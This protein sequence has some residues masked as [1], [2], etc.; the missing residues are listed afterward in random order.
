[1]INGQKKNGLIFRIRRVSQSLLLIFILFW[2]VGLQG[3]GGKTEGRKGP[4]VTPTITGP[5][6]CCVNTGGYIYYTQNGMT[7]YVWSVSPGGNFTGQGTNTIEVSWLASG[8]QSVSVI[9]NG[10]SG[11]TSQNIQVQENITA[12]VAISAS[13]NNVCSGTLVTFTATPLN[14]GI[15]PVYQWKVNGINVGFNTQTYDYAP[16]NGDEVTCQMTSGELCVTN[17]PVTS[18]AIVM[19][20]NPILPVSVSISTLTN[21]SC[22]GAPVTFTAAPVNG[23]TLPVYQWYVNSNLQA[24]TTGNFT[25]TPA[26]N[27]EVY[28]SMTSNESCISGNP[29][30]SNPII[31]T[32]SDVQ[33]VGVTIATPNNPCCVGQTALF[34]ATPTNGGTSPAYQWMVNGSPQGSNSPIFSFIP[35]EGDLVTCRLTSNS[36]CATGNPAYSTP[37]P[38]SVQSYVPVSVAISASSNPVCNGTG[39]T[40]SASAANGGIA[41]EY[42][43]YVN[44]TNVGTNSAQYTY[45]PSNNDQVKCILISNTLCPA[46]SPATSNLINMVVISSQLPTVT[47]AASSNPSCQ[48]ASVTFTATAQNAGSNPVYQWKIDGSNVGPNS[49]TYSFTPLNGQVVSCAVTSNATCNSGATATSNMITMTV[50]SSLNVSVSIAVSANPICAGSSATFTATG[51]HGG[52]SPTYQWKVGGVNAGSNSPTYTYTPNNGDVVTCVMTSS[53]SCS[54]GNPATSNAITMSVSLSLPAS[55]SISANQ[56][57]ACAGQVVS[58]SATPVNGGSSPTYTWQVNSISVGSGPTFTTSPNNGDQVTCIMTSSSS[59]ATGSP[60]TSNSV[61]MTINPYTAVGVSILSSQNPSCQG[62]SVVFTATPVNPGTTPVYEWKVNGNVTGGNQSTL[63]YVPVSGDKIT[64]QL[65][66]SVLCPLSNPVLSNQITQTVDP[67]VNASV[68]VSPSANPVCSGTQVTFSAMP[69]NGGT[70]PTYQWKV[71][72]L[73]AGSNNPTLILTPINS[74]VVECRMTSSLMCVSGNPVSSTPVTMVVSTQLTPLITITSSSNPFC[75]GSLV[76]FNASSTYGGSAPEYQWRVNGSPVGSNSPNYSYIPQNGDFV[77][78]QLTSSLACATGPVTSNY[79][80][81]T[82]NTTT[83]AGITI[84]ANANPV[85]QGSPVTFTA[86][87]VNGGSSPGYQWKVNGSN[88]GTNSPTF[89]FTPVNNDIVTCVL[90]SNASCVSGS[91]FT[92]LPV[93]LSVTSA[94]AATI[95][96]TP[97]FNPF[98]EGSAVTFNSSITNGGSAPVYNWQVNG[99]GMGTNSPTFTHSPNNGDV[100]T[101]QLTSNASCISGPNPVTSP[102]VVMSSAAT[103]TAGVS[104]TASANP[105]C[106]GT[107]V[108][109]TATPT[110]GGSTPNYQWKV[111]GV[112]AGTNNPVFSYIPSNGQVITCVM[113]SSLSCSINNPAT[114]NA[115][116]MTVTPPQPVSVTVTPSINPICIGSTVTLTATPVNGGSSPVYLWRIN[117][118]QAGTNSNTYAYIPTN[119]DVITCQ[120]T[121]NATCVSNNPAI[122]PSLVMQVG[123]ELP[124]AITISASANPFCTGSNVTFTSVIA[125]GGTAPIYEWF[126]NGL[127]VG[128]NSPTYVYPPVSGDIV[129]CRVTSNQSCICNNPANSNNITMIAGSGLP[130]SVSISTPTTTVCAG[131]LVIFTATPTNGGVNPNYQW[132]I[133]NVNAGINNATF[134]PVVLNNGDVV[135]CQL[136]SSLGCVTG[137]PATSNAITM[138]VIPSAPVSITIDP[139]ANPSCQGSSVTFTAN[140][141]NGGTSPVY[142]WKVNGINSGANSPTYSFT[143]LNNDQVTCRLTSNATCRTGNPATS[144]TVIMTVNPYVPVA[145]AISAS[146][147]PVCQGNAVT[148]TATPTNGGTTPAYQWKVNGIN[149]G[150]NSS[151]FTHTPLNG[152]VITCQMTSNANCISVNTVTSNPI[153]MTVSPVVP[154]SV[155]VSASVN[156]SC[157]GEIVTFTATPVNGG[158][159]PA[160]QWMVNGS[161]A[162]TNSATYAYAP[163][164]GDEISCRLTSNA[165]CSSGNPAVSAPVIASVTQNLPADITISASANYI[166]QGQPITFTATAANGG[167][168]PQYQWM[169]QGMNVGPNSNEYTYY[170]TNGDIVSCQ[171][172]SSLSCVSNNPAVSN[173]IEMVL[174]PYLPVGISISS[175]G[176]P[177]CLGTVVTYTATPVNPGSTPAY[178]W[179]VN[180]LAVGINSPSYSYIPGN[181]DLIVCEMFSSIP[182]AL[183]NPVTSNTITMSVLT[184]QTAGI[185]ISTTTNPACQGTN[186]TFTASTVN[187]GSSPLYQWR[188][189]GAPAGANNSSFT[190][191]PSNGDIITCL[192]TSGMTCISNNPVLSN[193]ITME[194]RTDFPA[195]ITV[196]PSANPVCQGQQVTFNAATVNGGLTP[197]FQWFNNGIYVGN[198]TSYTYTPSNGNQIQC[199][200]TSSY[201]CASNNPAMSNLVTMIVNPIVPVSVSVSPSSNPACLGL[202]VT[203]TATVINGGSNPSFQWKVNGTYVGPNQNTYTYT[204]A[205]GNVITCQVTSSAGCISNNPANSNMVTM[206]IGS[207]FPVSVSINASGNPICEGTG[208]TFTAIPTYGGSAPVY[209]WKVNG[210][211]AGTNSPTF[212]TMPQNNDVVTCL[213]T[214]NLTCGTG[215]PATSN[216][217]T[218]IVL[219]VPVGISISCNPS[220]PVCGGTPVTFMATPQNGGPFPTYLWKVNGLPAGTNSQ[221]FSYLPQNGDVVSCAITSNATC[222]SGNTAYSNE[223]TMSVSPQMPVS[224]SI[225]AD[226][227]GFVCENTLV[228]YSATVTNPG[229][230]PIYEWFVNSLPVGTNSGTYSYIPQQ[231]DVVSCKLTSDIICATGNPSSSNTIAMVVL[232]VPVSVSISANP[233]TPVCEG[234]AVELTAT[235]VNGGPMPTY[236]WKVN[237]IATGPNN[238]VF[239]YVPQNT[240]LVT[241]VL[242]SNATC[243]VG[244]TA[245]SNAISLTVNPNLPVS[246]SISATP[247]NTLC[248]G[249]TVTLTTLSN[250]PGTTPTYQW[251]LNN[252]PAG[253]NTTTFSFIPQQGDFV[254]CRLT[255]DATCATGNP[256]NSNIILMTVNPMINA[257]ITISAAPGTTVCD[258]T[259][260]TY[261]AVQSNG[262]SSPSFQWTV[263]GMA[264]GSN[265]PLFT[266][267]PEN[268]DIVNCQLTTSASCP[269]TNPVVSNTLPITVHPLAPVSVIIVATPSGPVFTGETVS[270]EAFPVNGGSSP[271]YQWKVNGFNQGTNSPTFSYIPADGDLVTC[272]LQSN[273]TCPV[274][275]PALAIPIQMVVNPY[276]AVSVN[277]SAQPAGPVCDGTMVTYTAVPV[278][279]GT[280]PAFQ[281]YLNGVPVGGNSP[282]YSHIPANGDHLFCIL[283]SSEAFTVGNPASSNL[284]TSNVVMLSTPAVSISGVPGAPVCSGTVVTLTANPVNG[285]TNPVYQ[286][287]VNGNTVGSNNPVYAFVPSNGDQVN[288]T[289]NSNAVCLASNPASSTPVILPVAPLNAVSISITSD[290]PTGCCAGTFVTITAVPVNPGLNPQYQWRVNGTPTGTNAPVFILTPNDNDLVECLLTST[291]ACP[292][293][294]P[295]TSNLLTMDVEPIPSVSLTMCILQTTR[296]ARPIGLRGGLPLGGTYSGPAVTGGFFSPGSLPVGQTSATITY[297]YTGSAGCGSSA[298]QIIQVGP[299]V[300]F[301]CGDIWTDFRDNLTYPTVQIGTQCWFQSNLNYGQ[302]VN[303]MTL[304]KD[305]CIV[306]KY[307]FNNNASNC[308][309]TGGLYLWDEMMEYS[310]T[311]GSQGICPPGWHIPDESDWNTLFG[312]YNGKGMAGEQ[313][314]LNGPTFMNLAPKGVLHLGQ[315]WSFE[316]FASFFWSSSISGSAKGYAHGINT[317]TKSISD[318]SGARTNGFS[319]R[320]VRN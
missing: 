21:P 222:A 31:M 198:G 163:S 29:A 271:F 223:I 133:N 254:S 46:G 76:S 164:S 55:V 221:T 73:A 58:F 311:S 299:S 230:S 118:V 204:P 123:T 178:Q 148:F 320:C 122:S 270:F 12:G 92:S 113:T 40:F 81:M 79:I 173:N 19:T 188:I 71:N 228:T 216:A 156:P 84:T 275:N 102:A 78:C 158:T 260:V 90:T 294:N 187:G 124:V 273:E 243:A 61:T 295:A 109:Y 121:S 66:S 39:V 214:S 127:P 297:G 5:A 54:S 64:C 314:K 296:D 132:K 174:Y 30:T 278:N 131:S 33:P 165:T 197:A 262:G 288:C 120:V 69:T 269:V 315:T 3:Q 300:A 312:Y 287:Y 82:L 117:G 240:D 242:A 162:G 176:N 95:T 220:G 63:T 286:W 318:Y 103:L 206:I 77:T 227:P 217:I 241:C 154:V 203:Y 277:I 65:N 266:H 319:V 289:M 210:S 282:I 1:M 135:T 279:G 36:G 23:G 114:S 307:C 218:M 87:P 192:L 200:M 147:N 2:Q 292:S 276:L 183:N 97:Q 134:Q 313:L 98:C 253:T 298:T 265:Q 159:A 50:S 207:S 182:C 136:T 263:N 72:G 91:P 11:S 101:C 70:S 14:G 212:A 232:P 317:L 184:P 306:E 48:G 105:V 185:S 172:I 258:G 201:S 107:T 261:T 170:P 250:N 83:P 22:S 110:N 199:Q 256:A 42:E 38:M 143:P 47:I 67:V 272:E 150:T 53:L 291:I 245:T 18:N 85:C 284:I 208:A 151:T 57:P 144:N 15:T 128:S 60:A 141:V 239:S 219:P 252:N 146:A 251:L 255:S 310:E 257:G 142:Q 209:Q 27:D 45:T 149:A 161:N 215:N 191:S 52:M 264:T 280:S 153:T 32:V 237:G 193:A 211:A 89:T 138:T 116:T 238:P 6:V 301:T 189:N 235:A 9:F 49:P 34:T 247:G 86:V 169:V 20:I 268:G 35:A 234:T 160:Y 231:G 248:Q 140:P 104:I 194:V 111:S 59:C 175:S 213:L 108:L 41:P 226:P 180:G 205:N 157:L 26:D 126:V 196:T 233:S 37:V 303:S 24:E 293:V 4:F 274:N 112:N 145:V 100:I 17:S 8:L 7:G 305:N 99:T 190:Y 267:V 93:T 152:E 229:N 246:V 137:N 309:Q 74:D 13:A 304:Q 168:S 80:F 10:A 177:S 236:T 166:C 130:V 28:C 259:A 125:N 44:G 51:V 302:Q 139:S 68:S 56:N 225:S 96:I 167:P 290:H 285:G 129:S 283:T 281:W 119:N 224:I 25:Y 316:S 16:N 115:I 155:S 244:N 75:A 308:S 88:Q 94:L 106:Q 249:E 171:L 179:K 202:P 62:S 43:W 195:A 186:V 181:G